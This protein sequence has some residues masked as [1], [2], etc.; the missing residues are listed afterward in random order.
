M[1]LYS[2]SAFVLD[3]RAVRAVGAPPKARRPTT[4]AANAGKAIRAAAT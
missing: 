2:I 3:L 1:Y 4:P